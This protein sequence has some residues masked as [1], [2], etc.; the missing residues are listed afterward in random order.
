LSVAIA[1]A[2]SNNFAALNAVAAAITAHP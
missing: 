2:D 1:A